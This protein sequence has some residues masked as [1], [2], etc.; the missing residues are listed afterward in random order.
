MIAGHHAA[1]LTL[2][3]G[4]SWT[5]YDGQVPDTPSFPY[6]VL[7]MDTGNEDG[8][9][10]CGSS[11]MADFRFQVTSVGLTRASAVV[12]ADA[13]RTLLLDVRPTVAG[14]TCTRIRRETSIPVRADEDVT[15]TDA[16]LKP[17]FAVDT[18]HFVSYGA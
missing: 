3:S 1:V 4:L 16:N 6:A 2:L 15:L 7:Y 9:K 5:L 10:L 18:Y 12:V 13:V 11:D 8:T 14:R 17:M